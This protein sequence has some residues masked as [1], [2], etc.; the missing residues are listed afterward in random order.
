MSGSFRRIRVAPA[1]VAD[2]AVKLLRLTVMKKDVIVIGG[3]V[4]GCC[5]ALG[6]ARAGLKVAVFE[7]GRV[8]CESSRAAAGMLSPQVEA[9]S[10]GPFL[11]LCL[12]SRSMYRGYAAELTE[13][14]GIDVEYRDEGTLCVAL[15]DEEAA[16]IGGWASWQV[17]AGLRI[18]QVPA[19]SIRKMEP[20][21]T[22]AALAAIFIP[23]DH[24]VESRRLMDA[25]CIATRR[26]GVEMVEGEE[27]SGLLIER[28]RATGVACGNRR[29]HAGAV[30]VAAGSWS[31]ELLGPVG[32]RIDVTPARGQMIAVRGGDFPTSRVLHSKR[33][34]LVPRKDG[35]TLIGATVEYAG[36]E[37]ALTV[38]GINSLLAAAI[39]L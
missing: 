13:A 20:A 9:A 31:S 30:V 23:D 3:G 21:V 39:E 7:R 26:A 8:G 10:R 24:Q 19:N 5:I 34:Y 38:G 17:D 2:P 32:V 37:K 28:E 25:L 12:R 36:F 6:L 16:E 18:E 4:I 27:V 22:E 1:R 15:N 35:R 29:F 14:S 33:C 11:D